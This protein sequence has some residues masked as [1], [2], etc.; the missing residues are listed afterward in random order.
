MKNFDVFVWS[1]DFEEFTGEG[2]LARSFIKTIHEDKNLTI[3]V[4]SNTGVYFLNNKKIYTVKKN[5]YE[6][7]FFHKYL[8]IFFGILLIWIISSIRLRVQLVY[9]MLNQ[10]KKL[11]VKILTLIR[12][13]KLVM[14]LIIVDRQNLLISKE[15]HLMK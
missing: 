4:I 6:N 7:N 5:K 2:L 1:S 9:L 14:V 3:K 11:T 8:K 13:L 12:Y 15:K 10:V